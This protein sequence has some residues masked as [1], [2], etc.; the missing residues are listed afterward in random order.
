M[1]WHWS[2]FVPKYMSTNIRGHEALLHHHHRDKPSST[3]QQCLCFYFR[4]PVWKENWVGFAHSYAFPRLQ[5]ELCLWVSPWLWS[6]A[7]NNS[8]C[9]SSAYI[10]SQCLSWTVCQI[11]TCDLCNLFGKVK[12][13]VAHEWN[14]NEFCLEKSKNYRQNTESLLSMNNIEICH[15]TA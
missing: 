3:L 5:K 10:A 12:E 6:L 9:T 11:Q 13:F 4:V 1:L 8:S 7:E 14:V 15:T 2:L